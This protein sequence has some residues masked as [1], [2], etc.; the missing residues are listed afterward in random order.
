MNFK[1]LKLNDSIIIIMI[2]K[3]NWVAASPYTVVHRSLLLPK[4]IFLQLFRMNLE[5]EIW[6]GK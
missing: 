2:I 6:E 3:D 1:N 5:I 4:M